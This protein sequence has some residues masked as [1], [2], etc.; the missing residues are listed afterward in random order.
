MRSAI[1]KLSEAILFP[2]R[3][4]HFNNFQTHVQLRPYTSSYT[5]E[6]K[7]RVSEE[8]ISGTADA[9]ERHF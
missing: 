3:A 6:A 9:V 2:L 7:R 1:I 4:E 8:E 5:Q